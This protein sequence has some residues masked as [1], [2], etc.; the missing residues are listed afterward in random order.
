[1][2]TFKRITLISALLVGLGAT[3]CTDRSDSSDPELATGAPDSLATADVDFFEAAAQT[4]MTEM[5]AATLASNRGQSADTQ[6]YA[7]AMTADHSQHNADLKA[8]AQ[9]K[10]VTL[11]TQLD[12]AHQSKLDDLAKEDAND[13]DQAYAEVMVEGHQDA[14]DLFENTAENSEDADIRQFA[15]NSLPILKRHLE[16]AQSMLDQD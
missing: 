6:S 1:M 7:T 2:M 3:A 9:R 4:G 10:G 14:V 5:S 13:F 15:S 12:S 16:M 11:P 8:L